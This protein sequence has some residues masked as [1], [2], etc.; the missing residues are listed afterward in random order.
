M[1]SNDTRLIQLIYEQQVVQQP[2]PVSPQQQQQSVPMPQQQQSIA[3]NQQPAA[4]QQSVKLTTWG[5]LQ[6]IIESIKQKLNK[7]TQ[8]QGAKL[9]SKVA[10]DAML[11]TLGPLAS[12]VTNATSVYDFFKTVTRQPDSKKTGTFIDQL[13]VDDAFSDLVDDKVEAAFLKSIEIMVNSHQ[14]NEP[15]PPNWNMT[16]ELV[17]FLKQRYSK[18]PAVQ[19]HLMDLETKLKSNVSNVVAAPV[20]GIQQQQPAQPGVIQ[21]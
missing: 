15:L 18:S 13:D 16:N 14:P 8:K 1:H 11:G 6:Q 4:S 3:Q 20:A 21:A 19:Q 12:V 5:D 9:A 10:L 7:Q 17:K 2:A